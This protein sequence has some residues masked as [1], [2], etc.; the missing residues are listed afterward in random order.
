MM[1]WIVLCSVFA[2]FSCGSAVVVDYDTGRSFTAYKTYDFYP[3]IASGL[4]E[5]DDK[6]I[7]RIT[8]SLLREK[9]FRRFDE[10]D[11]LVNF[12]ATEHSE[13]P[14]STIGVG[15]GGGGRNVGVGVSGGIPIG[16]REI[17]QKFTL[18]LIDAQKDALIWQG[19]L[20]GRYKE[21]STPEIKEQHYLA[22][23]RKILKEFPPKAQ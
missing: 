17:V 7:Q 2:L 19:S 12:Y 1:K 8:D 5:L 6:R 15:I 23:L 14:R 9:G 11:L 21:K 20:E 10:P 13:A 18:D 22:V 3:D 4:T 16:G